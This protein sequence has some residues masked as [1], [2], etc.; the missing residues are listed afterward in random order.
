MTGQLNQ[1]ESFEELLRQFDE[2][3]ASLESDDLSLDEAIA[4]YERAALLARQCSSI[5]ENAELR[6]RQIDEQLASNGAH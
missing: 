2:V 5:L 6:V 3:V 1:E 4:R